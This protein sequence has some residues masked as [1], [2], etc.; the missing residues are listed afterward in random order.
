MDKNIRPL[1]AYKNAN[2]SFY[3]HYKEASGVIFK[4]QSKK[5]EENNWYW[6]YGFLVSKI[7]HVIEGEKSTGFYFHKTE[8]RIVN[9][10]TAV[11][12]GR[13]CLVGWY[14]NIENFALN[15]CENIYN[16]FCLKNEKNIEFNDLE[17]AEAL[18]HIRENIIYY[19]NNEDSLKIYMLEHFFK[20]QIKGILPELPEE[21]K[22]INEWKEHFENIKKKNEKKDK[23]YYYKRSDELESYNYYL[24]QILEEYGIEHLTQ[25]EYREREEYNASLDPDLQDYYKKIELYEGERKALILKSKLLT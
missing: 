13:L 4:T 21:I 18:K 14:Y 24:E 25:E 1:S 8:N 20:E 12:V 17:M 2:P 19:Y 9:K 15:I 11:E 7:P 23:D 16:A 5:Q 22:V 3:T 6:A 10:C